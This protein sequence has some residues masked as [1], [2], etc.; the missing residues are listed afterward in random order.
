MFVVSSPSANAATQ[1]ASV[2]PALHLVSSLLHSVTQWIPTVTSSADSAVDSTHVHAAAPPKPGRLESCVNDSLRTNA[3]DR[4]PGDPLG[5][6][7]GGDGIVEARDVADVA[8]QSSV[9]HPLDNLTQ[10][11]T[12]GLDDEVDRQAVGRPR[13]GGPGDGHQRPSG[14]DHACGPLL[15]VAADDVEHQVDVAEVF[16]RVVLKVDE[17]HRAEV[18]RRLTVGRPPGADD[19]SAE[20]ACEL[21]H[22][23]TD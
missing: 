11:G 6:I 1:S 19:V 16:Q 7:E 21:D 8:P 14:S 3:D 5:R 20:L 10:L 9:P 22:H 12:I 13:L 15:D 2:T 18:E 4:L 23:R 17:L